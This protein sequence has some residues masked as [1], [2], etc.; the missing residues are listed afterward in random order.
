MSSEGDTPLRLRKAEAAL[1]GAKGGAEEA[2]QF[3]K[4]VRASVS[5][6]DDIHVSADYRKNLIG[7]L[8]EK[9]FAAAWTRAR[10]EKP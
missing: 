7:A 1:Y 10:G 5:P 3:A 8:A 9:A 6:S 2:S 4:V